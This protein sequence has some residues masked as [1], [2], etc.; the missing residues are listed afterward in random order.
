MNIR[1]RKVDESIP[2]LFGNE[3]PCSYTP[4]NP[5]QLDVFDHAAERA[6]IESGR[7]VSQERSMLIARDVHSK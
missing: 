3:H 7:P 2:D 6:A 4:A 5:V 1:E